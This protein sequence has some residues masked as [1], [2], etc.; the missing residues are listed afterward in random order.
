MKKLTNTI[1]SF[2]VAIIII[3]FPIITGIGIGSDWLERESVEG[4]LIHPI[5]AIL[6]ALCI[7]VTIIEVGVLAI[8]ASDSYDI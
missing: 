6:L 8:A 7:A 3:A 5:L 1:G 4:A 2:V